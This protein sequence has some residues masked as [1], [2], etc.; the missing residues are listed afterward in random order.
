[1][2]S[3]EDPVVQGGS[4]NPLT[5]IPPSGS[6]TLPLVPR[7]QQI[8]LYLP[9]DLPDQLRGVLRT[10]G[11]GDQMIQGAQLLV[12]GHVIPQWSM[13]F[14]VNLSVEEGETIFSMLVSDRMEQDPEASAQWYEL[15]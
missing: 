6:M 7:G 13:D 14:S 4:F 5:V 12:N 1:M 2:G 10:L 9:E 15:S 11:L 3:D 8:T